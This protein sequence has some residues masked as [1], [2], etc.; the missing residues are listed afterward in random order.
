MR[1]CALLETKSE[2]SMQGYGGLPLSELDKARWEFELELAF[3]EYKHVRSEIEQMSSE[4][5][6]SLGRCS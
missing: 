3:E 6:E 4:I 1:I 2:Y 5:K